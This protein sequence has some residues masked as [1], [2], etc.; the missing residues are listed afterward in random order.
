MHFKLSETGILSSTTKAF[1]EEKDVIKSIL[2]E[3]HNYFSFES[4]IQGKSNFDSKKRETLVQILKEQ[5][6]DIS[7][8]EHVDSAVWNN[9]DKLSNSNTFTVTT[10]Q[11]LHP[12]FGPAFVLY[13]IISII[14]FCEDLNQKFPDK[15]F[16]PV[17]WPAS[18]DHDFD[19]I[20]NTKVFNQNFEWTTKSG[21]ACGRLS[22]ESLSDVIKEISEKVNLTDQNLKML[23]EFDTIYKTSKNLSE[24]TIRIVNLYFGQYGVICVNGDNK[25]FKESFKDIIKKD[26][27][28]QGN[29]DSFKVTS[30]AL[31][32]NGLSTQLHA[33]DINFFYLYE[34]SRKRIVLNGDKFE[35][36]DGKL[37]STVSEMSQLI[38]QFP[39]RFSPNAMMR[40]LYQECILPNIAYVGGNAEI[41]YWVQLH[42]VMNNNSLPHPKLILRPSVWITTTKSHQWLEK[43]GISAVELLKT[44]DDAGLLNLLSDNTPKI[45]NQ[46]DVFNNLKQDVQNIVA[47]NISTELK[48]F[49]EAGKVYEKQLKHVSKILKETG[50]IKHEA[51]LNKLKEIQSNS[52]NIKS[53]QERKIDSL[54]M[55]IKYKDVVFSVKNAVK[56]NNTFGH[57]ISM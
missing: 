51:D 56:L 31:V 20:K 22:T 16:V 19:E 21:D 43:R 44:D 8:K 55:L 10:G 37:I 6:Q 35:D 27:L 15:H 48:A 4:A 9:I 13:K 25:L 5:Y 41:N 38:D 36:V 39:E 7:S 50:L 29:I 47:Q 49:V 3:H 57:I 53:I 52:L 14:D 30:D 26:V 28:E 42:N 23:A 34:S 12:F 33:R 40:P 2:G 45:D 11:Q 32:A 46:I 18:E 1:V 17:Y 54:E 24:A